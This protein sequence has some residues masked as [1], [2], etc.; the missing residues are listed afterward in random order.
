MPHILDPKRLLNDDDYCAA[1]NELEGLMAADPD[2]PQFKEAL[3]SAILSTQLNSEFV[4][5]RDLLGNLY[6][7]AG[8]IDKSVDRADRRPI[9][10]EMDFLDARAENPD[11]LLGIAKEDDVPDV[12]DGAHSRAPDLIQQPAHFERAK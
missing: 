7:K 1:L 3:A 6:L 4:L 9:I 12:E 5:A 2:T 10:L 11:P 8:Q